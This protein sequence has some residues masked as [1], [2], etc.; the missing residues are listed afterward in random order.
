MLRLVISLGCVVMAKSLCKFSRRDIK[1]GKVAQL[2][3]DSQ[4]YCGSCA[5][6]SNQKS[7]LCK[8]M[9]LAK[10]THPESH[11]IEKDITQALQPIQ[12]GNVSEVIAKAKALKKQR[13]YSQQ[14]MIKPL[15]NDVNLVIPSSVLTT[16]KVHPVASELEPQSLLSPNDMKQQLKTL[17]KGLKAQRKQQKKMKKL[18]K[19][20]KKL[21][22]QHKKVL[23]QE[24]KLNKQEAKITKKEARVESRLSHLSLV[25]PVG[26]PKDI[27][28]KVVAG[29]SLH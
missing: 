22:K 6:T 15:N 17:K 13:E 23:K 8:P 9:S 3:V 28:G 16:P 12:A 7:A 29:Q 1:A 25:E 18:L 2:V 27:E 5:R 4:F 10:L 20:Q 26:Y 21:A 24:R 14:A 19:K 11:H